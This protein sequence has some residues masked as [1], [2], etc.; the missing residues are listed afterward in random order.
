MREGSGRGKTSFPGPAGPGP[1]SYAPQ[2]RDLRDRG[3]GGQNLTWMA[4]PIN[5]P[6]HFCVPIGHTVQYL[7]LFA[8]SVHR[9]LL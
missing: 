7:L 1:F 9:K 8:P 4:P 3:L 6:C 5:L 2:F